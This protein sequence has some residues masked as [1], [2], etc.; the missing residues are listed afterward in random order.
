MTIH[1]VHFLVMWLPA[2]SSSPCVSV[3]EAPLRGGPG[4]K[5]PEPGPVDSQVLSPSNISPHVLVLFHGAQVLVLEK[6]VQSAQ[7]QA[8][9]D[10]S[11]SGTFVLVSNPQGRLCELQK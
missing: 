10:L 7:K 3:Y 11:K 8:L 4:D 6:P 2:W 5:I 9:G 1:H